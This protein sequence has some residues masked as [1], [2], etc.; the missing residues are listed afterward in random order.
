MKWN[1]L[2]GFVCLLIAAGFLAVIY[3]SGG[4][5]T[6]DE[7]WITGGFIGAALLLFDPEDVKTIALAAFQRFTGRA[8]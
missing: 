2:A 7:T 5:L 4:R 3:L 1:N 8:P 6:R